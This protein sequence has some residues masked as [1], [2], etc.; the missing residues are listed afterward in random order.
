MSVPLRDRLFLLELEVIERVKRA[1]ITTRDRIIH[2]C[3]D[4]QGQTPTEYL[5]IVGLM[6]AAIITIFVTFFWGTIKD[7]A[8]SWAG[9]VKDAVTGNGMQ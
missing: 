9:K 8:K 1:A 6:A 5:M 3:D 2:A 4:E 7:A